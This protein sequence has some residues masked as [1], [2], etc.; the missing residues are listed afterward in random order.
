MNIKILLSIVIALFFISAVSA[1]D[2]PYPCWDENTLPSGS[3]LAPG[4]DISFSIWHH[5]LWQDPINTTFILK[6]D[7]YI[8]Y[9][10]INITNP[11]LEY[12][13][14]IFPKYLSLNAAYTFSNVPNG[15]YELTGYS[16]AANGK[17]NYFITCDYVC[18]CDW[19]NPC[20]CTQN[21]TN[22][23]V[24]PLPTP[25]S[26]PI[27]TLTS[28]DNVTLTNQNITIFASVINGILN[29]LNYTFTSNGVFTF[30]A[31]NDTLTTNYPV[32]IN[33]IDKN[34]PIATSLTYST[35][36]LTN[37]NVIASITTNEPVTGT[38]VHTFTS[39]GDYTFIFT[40]LAGNNGEITAHVSNINDTIS[41]LNAYNYSLKI[42]VTYPLNITYNSNVTELR[43]IVSSPNKTAKVCWYNNGTYSSAKANCNV[44]QTYS[45]SGNSFNTLAG[46]NTWIVYVEDSMGRIN[47]SS[48]VFYTNRSTGVTPLVAVIP[49][50]Q[51]PASQLPVEDDPQPI[52]STTDSLQYLKDN[53][54]SILFWVLFLGIIGGG[55]LFFIINRRPGENRIIYIKENLTVNDTIKG[56][57][58]VYTEYINQKHMDVMCLTNLTTDNTELTHIGKCVIDKQGKTINVKKRTF[59]FKYLF[60][61][62]Q[63]YSYMWAESST[64]SSF[65]ATLIAKMFKKKI[66][67]KCNGYNIDTNAKGKKKLMQY[68]TSTYVLKNA[69]TV[70][71]DT[72]K[73]FNELANVS[74]KVQI[75]PNCIF[76]SNLAKMNISSPKKN[77]IIAVGKIESNK[78]LLDILDSFYIFKGFEEGS[79]WV[80]K[81]IGPSEDEEYLNVLTDRIKEL[82]LENNV[83][84]M[85][86]LSD[87][88]LY[89]EMA[90]AK[91]FISANTTEEKTNNDAL[92]YSLYY[93]C[94]PITTD[95]SNIRETLE[96]KNIKPVPSEDIDTM[97]KAIKYYSKNTKDRNIFRKYVENA[98]DWDMYLPVISELFKNEQTI[99]NHS[100]S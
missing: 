49:T 55:S 51:A 74:E 48:V 97:A 6:N 17:I 77:N 91:M 87:K 1:V 2:V 12:E 79:N 7:T 66:I 23:T 90:K 88:E 52:E 16:T 15:V 81:I 28:Y 41:Y 92:L 99:D 34:V 82:G 25:A 65:W 98:L 70:I 11:P 71:V 100:M 20:P 84:I 86:A 83:R 68:L 73:T 72:N 32:V 93:G 61:H 31:T 94:Q 40:D 26:Q 4:S 21:K 45:V 9:E 50:N 67:I 56:E 19:G 60:S 64:I 36:A 62:R 58:R 96:P 78:G 38:L 37:D 89:T 13:F 63:K 3:M 8:M 24:G 44:D 54:K 30:I 80:L 85:G 33:N 42:N 39:N 47:S 5:P 14:A 69:E 27:I 18:S 57:D 59:P 76:V 10:T 95:V 29:F 22:I 53:Y 46:I 75:I 43:F 35:T